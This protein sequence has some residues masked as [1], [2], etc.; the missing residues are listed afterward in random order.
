MKSPHFFPQEKQTDSDVLF[1]SILGDFFV[2][3]WFIFVVSLSVIVRFKKRY[4]HVN[5]TVQ[6]PDEIVVIPMDAL[7]IS[8]VLVNILENAVHHANGMTELRFCVEVDENKAYFSII[9]NGCGIEKDRLLNLFDGYG[10]E[11]DNSNDNRKRNAGIG[12][13]VCASI[14]KAH[15][16]FICAENQREGGAKFTFDLEREKGQY[17]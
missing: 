12:L 14:I 8:Q 15:G 4:P 3:F 13:S 16:G 2:D 5:I 1:P 7:L 10:G 6:I 17:E 11:K 9:D